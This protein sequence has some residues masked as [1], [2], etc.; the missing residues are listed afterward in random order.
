MRRLALVVLFAGVAAAQIPAIE[1]DKQKAEILQHHRALIQIDT[2]NPPG[3]ETRIRSNTG[4]TATWSACLNLLFTSL[5][6]S[7]GAPLPR[8][9]PTNKAQQIAVDNDQYRAVKVR[10]LL[11]IADVRSK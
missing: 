1:W 8:W 2:S 6:N 10:P 7:L 9:R 11:R 3:N 5:L 4:R